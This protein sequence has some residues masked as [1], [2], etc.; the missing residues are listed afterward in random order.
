[1]SLNEFFYGKY[2]WRDHTRKAPH[3][4][5]TSAEKLRAAI[6]DKKYIK[7]PLSSLTFN[8]TYWKD[9]SNAA[10]TVNMKLN[11]QYTTIYNYR[12][13]YYYKYIDDKELTD[14]S[15][16]KTIYAKNIV[17]QITHIDDQGLGNRHD[18]FHLSRF[19]SHYG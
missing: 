8:D 19:I 6:K 15:N 11:P 18:F 16:N 9:T 1:M 10:N 5:Y 4:L 3:N 13:G 2:Y 17:V 14:K 12:D 7:T